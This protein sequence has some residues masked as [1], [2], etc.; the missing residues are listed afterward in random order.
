M[1]SEVF[2]TQCI[3]VDSPQTPK[4]NQIAGNARAS[5]GWLSKRWI[6]IDLAINKLTVVGV[7]CGRKAMSGVL[8][9]FSENTAGNLLLVS[10]SLL[11]RPAWSGTPFVS[12]SRQSREAFSCLDVSGR[13]FLASR[14]DGLFS[15]L[16]ICEEKRRYKVK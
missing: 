4:G 2:S 7:A 16:E 10:A 15:L 5:Y 12:S 14:I 1:V 13:R 11:L 8:S 9:M 3:S 6:L